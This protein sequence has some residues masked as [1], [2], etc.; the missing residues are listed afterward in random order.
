[1]LPQPSNSSAK[2]IHSDAI[3]S[4]LFTRPA[5]KAFARM[6]GAQ[7][8]ALPV[9]DPTPRRVLKLDQVGKDAAA[10]TI[11]RPLSNAFA[12]VN[13]DAP[14]QTDFNRFANRAADGIKRLH[15]ER[16]K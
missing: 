15:L 1:M 7:R 12:L 8:N 5:P 3:M 13:F 11:A 2:A 4:E 16:S 6:V 14:E 9:S 10:R